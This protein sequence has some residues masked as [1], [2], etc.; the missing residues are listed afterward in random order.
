M[1]RIIILTFK[2]RSR[3]W[4]TFANSACSLKMW[5][6]LNG[7]STYVTTSLRRHSDTESNYKRNIM[8]C[9]R[10]CVCSLYFFFP[11]CSCLN[12]SQRKNGGFIFGLVLTLFCC[13]ISLGSSWR[14]WR[15]SHNNGNNDVTHST[16]SAK[17]S[18][19]IHYNGTLVSST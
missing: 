6:H 13:K 8:G 15:G 17:T 4:T 3:I 10:L 2:L 16:S 12:E 1:L 19:K 7:C 9:M 18:I 11:V 5:S 14:Y